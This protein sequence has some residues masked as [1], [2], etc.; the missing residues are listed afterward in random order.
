MYIHISFNKQ[1]REIRC[2]VKP[3]WNCLPRQYWIKLLTTFQFN[4]K[5]LIYFPSF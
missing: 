5:H 3:I 4:V 1:K 2:N